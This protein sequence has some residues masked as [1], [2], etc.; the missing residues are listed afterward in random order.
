MGLGFGTGT[1]ATCFCG[2]TDH[3]TAWLIKD[4]GDKDAGEGA[5]CHHCGISPVVGVV[6]V[7]IDDQGDG[8]DRAE[9]GEPA[10]DDVSQPFAHV[11]LC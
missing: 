2:R 8:R 10:N 4:L 11:S 7:D 6:T 9:A 5:H 1:G 3:R